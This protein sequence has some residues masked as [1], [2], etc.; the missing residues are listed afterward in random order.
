MVVHNMVIHVAVRHV[1]ALLIPT[2]I[3]LVVE[4]LTNVTVIVMEYSV[5]HHPGI[6]IG[7]KK[8]QNH[9]LHHHLGK[10]Q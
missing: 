6:V 1:S 7:N 5:R 10:L 4:R 9:H 2:V 8:Y 3:M